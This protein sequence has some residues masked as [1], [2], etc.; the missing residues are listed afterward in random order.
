[1]GCDAKSAPD[2]RVPPE[3]QLVDG[4]VGQAVGI[5]AIGMTARD[6]EDPL[7]DQVRERVP[8]LP[9]GALVEQSTGRTP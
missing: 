8:N 5:V 4:V 3:Q 9:S 1:M 7:A 2:P 6:A